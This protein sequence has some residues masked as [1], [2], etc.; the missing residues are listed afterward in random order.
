[1]M[2]YFVARTNW[3]NTKSNYFMH[4][5]LVLN[6]PYY[7]NV[8]ITITFVNQVT[9]SRTFLL[10]PPENYPHK[11]SAIFQVNLHVFDVHTKIPNGTHKLHHVKR[12]AVFQDEPLA[13]PYGG[14]NHFHCH[15]NKCIITIIEIIFSSCH[16]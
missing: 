3:S 8:M 2:C 12:S 13:I 16:A 15:W 1:M 7:R 4:S 9:L 11:S 10:F 14:T 6:H 5:I